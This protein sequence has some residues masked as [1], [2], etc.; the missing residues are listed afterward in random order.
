MSHFLP[1]ISRIAVLFTLLWGTLQG[2][3][4][5]TTIGSYNP[6]SCAVGDTITLPVTVNMSS[7]ISTAAISMAVDFDTTKLR[8][9]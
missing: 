2:Q 1:K 9:L 3:N 7:G 6:T 4:I 5:T 8:A